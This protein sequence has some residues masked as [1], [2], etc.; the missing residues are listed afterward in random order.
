MVPIRLRFLILHCVSL[1]SCAAML[2]TEWATGFWPQE[3][4]ACTRRVEEQRHYGKTLR[5]KPFARPCGLPG[6][7]LRGPHAS[8]GC[9][10]CIYMLLCT[11]DTYACLCMHVCTG[12]SRNFTVVTSPQRQLVLDLL[13]PFE[14]MS[15]GTISFTWHSSDPIEHSASEDLRLLEAYDGVAASPTFATGRGRGN[16]RGRRSG[17][18]GVS[19]R[20]S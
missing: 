18:R 19:G 17:S 3:R 7:R 11:H 16:G 4:L 5:K 1:P 2:G 9:F 13:Y 10:I 15:A 14:R 20:G 12:S 6:K 8:A